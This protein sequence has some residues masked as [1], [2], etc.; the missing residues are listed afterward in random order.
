[1]PRSVRIFAGLL[2]VALLAL[3]T[4]GA[5]HGKLDAATTALIVAG[6]VV[7]LVAVIGKLERLKWGDVEAVFASPAAA[8]DDELQRQVARKVF[9]DANPES[10]RYRRLAL[11]AVVEAA[12]ELHMPVRIID[13]V[14]GI[15]AVVA[16]S[17]IGVDI[18]AGIGFDPRLVSKTYEVLLDRRIPVLDGIVTVV[19]C[20]TPSEA[21]S[22]LGKLALGGPVVPVAWQPGDS[23]EPIQAALK[24]VGTSRGE[25]SGPGNPV[26]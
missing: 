11:R 22:E 5:F 15:D 7:T 24:R 23:I 16:G 17:V 3:G 10:A 19:R 8:G 12:E 21:T 20:S 1:M 25:T 26:F 4:W 13:G 14:A 9:N 2:G 6:T 18:R